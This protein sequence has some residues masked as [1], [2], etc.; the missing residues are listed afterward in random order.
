M[1][2]GVPFLRRGPTGVKGL[3]H[4][5]KALL[6]VSCLGYGYLA[7]ETV[8]IHEL[9]LFVGHPTYAVTVTILAMLLASGLGSTWTGRVAPERRLPVLRMVLGAVL[10][11]GAIQAFAIPPLLHAVA[12][13]LPLAVRVGITFVVLFPLGFVMGMPFP[14]AMS[15]LDERAGGMV[16]W[17]WAL[18]GWMSVVASLVTVVVSRVA[19]YSTAFGVALGAYALALLLAGFLPRVGAR[20]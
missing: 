17:A 1:F 6:Y 12:L 20:D 9:V 4:L 10:V 18:N 7:V 19:G 2:I 8:L 13:G 14:L 3:R 11:L 16:P 15:Q 5:G